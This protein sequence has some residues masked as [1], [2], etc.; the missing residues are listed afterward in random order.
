MKLNLT[1]I[2]LL[3]SLVPLFSCIEDFQFDVSS[4]EN[5]IVVEGYISNLS[6]ED[7]MTYPLDPKIFEVSLRSTSQVKNVRDEPILGASVELHS[8][9]GAV[10]DYSEIGEGRYGL[11]FTDV[12]V[13]PGQ[14]Y[15]VVITLD[16]ESIIRSEWAELPESSGEG[17]LFIEETTKTVYEYQKDE[18]IIAENEGINLNIRTAPNESGHTNY[19]K[20]DFFTTYIFTA[21]LAED[22][23]PFKYCWANSI[24]YYQDFQ[25][26]EDSRGNAP[27][28]LF[29]LETDNIKLNE[30]FSVLIR[31][32]LM[33]KGYYQFMNDVKIQGEQSELFAKPPYNLVSNLYS[34]DV[35]VY[36]YFG[37]VNEDYKR[38]YFNKDEVT[39]YGGYKEECIF[40]GVPPPYPAS[41]FDCLSFTYDGTVSHLPPSWW[42]AQYIPR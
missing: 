2:S 18:L 29:F 21:F 5:G 28:N 17:E 42:D 16:D 13:V 1:H 27:A 23:D 4:E 33:S 25:L 20:W 11:F 19:Y 8:S 35:I 10:Y 41:C 31:Q 12:K 24:Y 37:V 7:Q 32:M 6:Y 38:W 14:E 26:L 30:G 9:S 39:N 15:Q 3:L 34:D 22:G 40:D 36:G